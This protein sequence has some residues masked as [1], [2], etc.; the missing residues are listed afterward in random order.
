MARATRA[1]GRKNL[2]RILLCVAAA[3][4]CACGNYEHK[5]LSVGGAWHREQA[6]SFEENLQA[7]DEA[8]TLDLYVGLRYSAAYP[9]KSLWVQV[10]TLAGGDSVIS[11]DTVCCD[12]YGDNGRRGGSTAGTL[13]QAEFF[14]ASVNALWRDVHAVRLQHIMQDSLLQGV[15]DVGIRLSSPCQRQCAEK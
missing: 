11:R 9:Y 10:E 15:Y 2:N 13:Y 5:Y 8:R 14:A 6:L 3:V 12:I 1:R 4:L 7:L